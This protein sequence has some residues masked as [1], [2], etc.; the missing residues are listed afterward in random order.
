M[1]RFILHRLSALE[2]CLE[3]EKLLCLFP[4]RS[5]QF[6]CELNNEEANGKSIEGDVLNYM[7]KYSKIKL[8]YELKIKQ[9]GDY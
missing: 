8:A 5:Y 7:Q 1:T 3:D 9:K 2:K 6:F 4:L